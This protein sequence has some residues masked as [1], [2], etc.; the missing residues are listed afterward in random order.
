MA[1]ILVIDDDPKVTSVLRRGLAFEGYTV[2]VAGSGREGLSIARDHAPDLAIVDLM[3][4]GI[5]GFEVLRRLRSAHETLPVMMLTARDGARDQVSGLDA[6][7]DDYMV[8]PFALPVLTARVKALLRRAEMD[9][10]DVLRFDDLALDTGTRIAVR[11]T[12]EIVLTATEYEVLRQ[13][14]L[15]PRRVLPKHFLMDRVWGYEMKGSSNVLEVYVKQLRQKLEAEGEPRV[16][17][18]F[19]GAGYVM[20]T[21]AA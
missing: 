8:K 19:R 21:S 20:R 13:F 1:R 4:P 14:M 10:P 9:H 7:A 12:R 16:I 15:H 5:D 3:L 17:H 6:G 2:D 11:G 18:T